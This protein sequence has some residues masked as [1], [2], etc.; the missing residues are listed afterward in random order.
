MLTSEKTY[1][2]LEKWETLITHRNIKQ[3][4][5]LKQ[6][7]ET[8]FEDDKELS[9]SKKYVFLSARYYF[10]QKNYSQ[11]NTI[12]EKIGS[13]SDESSTFYYQ[14]FK[15]IHSYNLKKYEDALESYYL[16]EKHLDQI[17]PAEQAEFHYKIA[18]VY[19]QIKE[20]LMSI[21]YTQRALKIFQKHDNYRLRQSDCSMLLA[22]NYIDM[23]QFSLAE[24]EFHEARD[25]AQK[26]GNKQALALVNHNLGLMYAE[27]DLSEA[28]IRYLTDV[29]ESGNHDYFL[30]TMFL[31]T[32]E[33][34]KLG[35]IE[36]AKEWLRKGEA[37]AEELGNNEYQMK[38]KL[39]HAIHLGT[40]EF[41]KTFKE[42]ISYFQNENLWLDVEE[43]AQ[44]FAR[45]YLQ[46]QEYRKAT[47][48]Y[49]ITLKAKNM[50]NKMEALI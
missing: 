3:A 39:L 48:Y 27:Q 31:L 7:I 19:Y 2:V 9:Q 29:I 16:A 45:F 15:G 22:L 42:G 21:N 13:F 38:L 18:S 47:E 14:F 33:H 50:I 11:A 41:E 17:P 30:Q 49:E 40:E 32:R 44:I 37:L 8:V 20:S 36:L 12:I 26:A 10:L 24:E 46:N 23:K 43:Y 6:E 28:A 35:R 25:K 4:K 5:E 1:E 34:F